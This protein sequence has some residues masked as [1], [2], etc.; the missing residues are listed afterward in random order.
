MPASFLSLLLSVPGLGGAWGSW[1]VNQSFSASD[2]A[3]LR[4]LHVWGYIVLVPR[5][6]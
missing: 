1:G 5:M 4:Y 6:M 2:F 3:S